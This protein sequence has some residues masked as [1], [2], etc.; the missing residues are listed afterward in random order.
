MVVLTVLVGLRV[1]L[2]EHP[3]RRWEGQLPYFSWMVRTMNYRRVLG[4]VHQ[5]LGSVGRD[6][7]SQFGRQASTHL[8]DGSSS[9]SP[10]FRR[11]L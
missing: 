7:P 5:A 4:V 11:L 3:R 6:W 1:R 9:S 8:H 10:G 2:T